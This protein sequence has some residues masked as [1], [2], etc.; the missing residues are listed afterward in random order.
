MK[1]GY[2]RLS[3]Q[4]NENKASNQTFD[5]QLLILKENGVLEENITE[6]RISGGVATSK[7]PQW[8]LLVEKLAAGDEIIISEMSRLARS[9]QDLIETVNFLIAK[10][11]GITFLKENIIVSENGL[12][13]MNKLVFNLFGAFAEFEKDLISERTKQGLAAKKAQ[14]VKLG[15]PVRFN[16]E[17][18]SLIKQAFEDGMVIVKM[19]ELFEISRNQ[20]YVFA[21]K[22]EWNS[23]TLAVK[24]IAKSN[25]EN[26]YNKY[27]DLLINLNINN[28]SN[29]SINNNISNLLGFESTEN[30]PT[31]ESDM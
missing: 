14:G 16:E 1:H 13:S 26:L 31:V 24:R 22:Y 20:I 7:R 3:T 23:P 17:Y 28:N 29:N 27:R 5:R 4:H 12:G 2:M 11:V 15:A 19:S 8:D 18:V 6:E 9:L 10:N 21:N 25:M 30:L